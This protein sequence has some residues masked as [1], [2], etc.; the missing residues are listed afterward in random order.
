VMTR[1]RIATI[2][3]QLAA[4]HGELAQEIERDEGRLVTASNAPKVRRARMR[5]PFTPARPPTEF[6]M[7]RARLRAKKLGIPLP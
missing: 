2:H 5:R 3:R 6:E 1:S 7:A 4:L